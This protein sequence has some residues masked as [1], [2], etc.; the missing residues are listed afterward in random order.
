MPD[1]SDGPPPPTRSNEDARSNAD[2][3]RRRCRKN[4]NRPRDRPKTRIPE[5]SDHV[6]NIPRGNVE[7]YVTNMREIVGY[8]ARTVPNG[9]QFVTALDPDDLGFSEL[10]EP[11]TRQRMHQTLR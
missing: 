6:L 7:S 2:G 4:R 1:L 3:S 9:G 8:I 10:N 11:T 5:L